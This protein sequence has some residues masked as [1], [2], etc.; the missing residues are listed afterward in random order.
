[1]QAASPLIREPPPAGPDTL[2]DEVLR[3]L[4]ADE[5]KTLRSPLE[6]GLEGLFSE[7]KD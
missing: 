4:S 2:E 7:A 3:T 6:R 1:L 5:R